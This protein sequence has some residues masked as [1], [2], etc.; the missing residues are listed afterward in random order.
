MTTST[1]RFRSPR[2][3]KVCSAGMGT[4]KKV[5]MTPKNKQQSIIPHWNQQGLTAYLPSMRGALVTMILGMSCASHQSRMRS[6]PS[7]GFMLF[8]SREGGRGA[9]DQRA[10]VFSC[11]CAGCGRAFACVPDGALTIERFL[12][13][14]ELLQRVEAMRCDLNGEMLAFASCSPMRSD[15]TDTSPS[16]AR[17]PTGGAAWGR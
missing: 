1:T 15:N 10:I 8:A 17:A 2:V 9:W 4:G 13:Q 7:R 16:Y 5:R 6:T 12:G 14:P 11:V 3:F